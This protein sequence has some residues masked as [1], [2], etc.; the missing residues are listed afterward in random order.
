VYPYS[1]TPEN[2]LQYDRV[3]LAAADE[4]EPV[5]REITRARVQKNSV[6]VRFEGSTTRN[7]AEGLVGSQLFI[8]AEDLPEPAENEFYLRDLEGRQMVTEEGRVIGRVTGILNIGGRNIARVQEGKQEYMIP[9]VP[10]FLLS[11]EG[12]VIQVA[13]PPGLLEINSK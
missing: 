5:I 11:L 9:L 2:F 13:L 4:R 8:Y 6:L 12:G 10:E 3:L 7:D 1:E